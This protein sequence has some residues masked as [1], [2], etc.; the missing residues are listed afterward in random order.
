MKKVI[1]I[2][3]S[4]LIAGKSNAQ[5]IVP[6]PSFEDTV[7][8]PLG[9]AGIYAASHWNSCYGSPDYFN[10]C[11]PSCLSPQTCV[12]IPNNFAG[13]QN[14]YTGNAYAGVMTSYY[15]GLGRE[16]IIVKLIDTLDIGKRYYF[17]CYISRAF[18]DECHGAS[19]NFCF[20]FSTVEFDYINIA[21]IDNFSHYRETSI[22]ID[23][24]N[25]T[26]VGSSFIADSAYQY[27]M[28]GNFYDDS[29]TDTLDMYLTTAPWNAAYYYVDEVCVT[30]DSTNCSIINNINSDMNLLAFQVYPN[31]CNERLYLS[32]TKDE[33][34][35]IELFDSFGRQALK[36]SISNKS[37]VD[38]S[39]LDPGIYFYLVRN[40][41][42]QLSVG[43]VL[44][45]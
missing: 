13:T 15:S 35:S 31:P 6:N 16:I 33:I 21:P 34:F 27:L 43:R 38:I 1:L 19:N 22:I 8:C 29:Q 4:F 23:T 42:G 41:N 28:L 30:Q 5:N 32:S 44:K 39:M 7:F 17:S 25:W 40:L 9:P 10:S 11:G 45:I 20:K 37:S 18:S 26:L 24:T 2:L 12:G 14:S 36:K 3:F